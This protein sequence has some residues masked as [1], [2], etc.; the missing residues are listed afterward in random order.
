ME[1]SRQ[2]HC[3]AAPAQHH[4]T[5]PDRGPYVGRHLHTPATQQTT[6]SLPRLQTSPCTRTTPPHPPATACLQA[7][8]GNQRAPQNHQTAQTQTQRATHNPKLY[9][10]GMLPAQQLHPIHGN[11]WTQWRDLHNE[12]MNVVWRGQRQLP[13]VSPKRHQQV[14]GKE[15]GRPR[16]SVRHNRRHKHQQPCWSALCSLKL[17]QGHHA[18]LATPRRALNAK[19]FAHTTRQPHKQGRY[20][21]PHMHV[22][23]K[24]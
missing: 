15:S 3:T 17:L 24:P 1:L 5:P 23:P 11:S 16:E 2:T 8:Q 21:A 18:T 19:L 12:P 10:P 14:M 22:Q 20:S 9:F 7:T 4:S 6:S 13:K